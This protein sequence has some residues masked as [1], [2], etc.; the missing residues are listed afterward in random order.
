[1]E[2]EIKLLLNDPK[3][4]SELAQCRWPGAL[5]VITRSDLGN[6]Y[7]DTPD[8]AL[9][10]LDMGLRIRRSG[11]QREQTL[12]T[13]G[14]VVG[15]LHAR[16]E[17]N[18]PIGSDHPDLSQFPETLWTPGQCQGIQQQLFAQFQTDFMR[19]SARLRWQG[20]EVELALDKGQIHA[21]ALSD[22]INELE[23]EL[24]QGDP[25]VLLDLTEQL[26]TAQPLRLG[27]DSKAAR[28]Y[29]LAGL[30]PE[31]E[32]VTQWA[33]EPGALLHAWQRNEARLMAGELAAAEPLGRVL[34]AQSEQAPWMRALLSEFDLRP[35]QA[36]TQ[37]Q[38]DRRYG[39]AQ[40]TLL[41]QLLSSDSE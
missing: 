40:L 24:V 2:I 12:K 4:I 37:L 16:P 9:R 11:E 17:Y 23:L 39:L 13:R 22:P 27:L 8:L 5:S 41:R 3:Q 10:R 25:A 34:Q 20:S 14:R 36:L 28:G 26:M 19:E 15:G 38:A 32:I 21:G 35:R 6:C 1:M 7:F 18:V 31:A 29:R 30:Q 33:D